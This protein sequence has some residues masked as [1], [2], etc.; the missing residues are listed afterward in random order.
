[1]SV[2]QLSFVLTLLYSAFQLS[3]I[4]MSLKN[5]ELD[6]RTQSKLN[7]LLLSLKRRLQLNEN[8]RNLQLEPLASFMLDYLR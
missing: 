5:N 3:I 2:V 4:G 6:I 1:M 7:S 8:D